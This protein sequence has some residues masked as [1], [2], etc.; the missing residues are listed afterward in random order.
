[1]Q[2][3]VSAVRTQVPSAVVSVCRDDT[4]LC[5]VH[6]CTETDVK[7]QDAKDTQTV[8]FS[9]RTLRSIRCVHAS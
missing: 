1:M 8:H 5:S 3:P 7:C 9:Q 2:H 4:M 6:M